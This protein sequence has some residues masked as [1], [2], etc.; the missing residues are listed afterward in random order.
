MYVADDK[1]RYGM[2]LVYSICTSQFNPKRWKFANSFTYM[3]KFLFHSSRIH[4]W[5]Y[6]IRIYLLIWAQYEE[7]AAS[8]APF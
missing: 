8:L 7:V 2:S 6:S 1:A 4:S 3:N 5:E